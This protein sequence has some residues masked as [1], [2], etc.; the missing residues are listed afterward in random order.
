[1]GPNRLGVSLP[2]SEDGNKTS[3]RNVVF[4]IYLEFPTMYKVQK[5]SDSVLYTIVR[6]H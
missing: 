3:F 1:M 2:S 5:L 4:S 6:T